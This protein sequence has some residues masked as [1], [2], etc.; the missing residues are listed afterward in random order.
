[1]GEV[2][3]PTLLYRILGSNSF[4]RV[5]LKHDNRGVYRGII[6]G[7]AR[8]FEWYVKAETS[9]GNVIFPATAG[10]DDS[11]KMYQTVVV[12]K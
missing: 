12:L 10:A 11:A 3:N 7:Q 2:K 5:P 8:D 1:M 4:N 9:L 6:P